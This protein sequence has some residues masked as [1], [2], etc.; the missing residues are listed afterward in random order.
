MPSLEKVGSM[1]EPIEVTARLVHQTTP[2]AIHIT[3]PSTVALPT[4][5]EQHGRESVSRLISKYAAQLAE[6]KAL[7]SSSEHYKAHLHDD[8]WL[9]RFL[10]SHFS[11]GGVATAARAALGAIEWRHANGMDEPTLPCGGP[12]SLKVPAVAKVYNGLRDRAALSY[13][14]PDPDRG[15]VLVAVPSMVD[16]HKLAANMTEEESAIAHRLSTEWLFRQCDV[17]TRRTGYLTKTVRLIDLKGLRLS[18]LNREFQ[19]RDAKNSKTL[20]D[21][22]PQLLGAVYLCHAPS[23]MQA[24]WRGMRTILPARVVEKVDFLEPKRDV[25]ER[26]RLMR[27]IACEHLPEC[28]GGPCEEWPPPNSR[29]LPRDTTWPAPVASS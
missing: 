13:Y 12:E 18:G 17:V 20:E 27:W 9:L 1:D 22:Y 21:F 2:G 7:V 3:L 16:F 19:R 28:F 24:V 26:A 4:G 5:F 10:L 15:T 29:F 6:L 8:I 23:W 25:R 14:V 11:K